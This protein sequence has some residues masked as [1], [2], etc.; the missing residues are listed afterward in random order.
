MGYD[1]KCLYKAANRERKPMKKTGEAWR[2]RKR[3]DKVWED[4]RLEKMPAVAY[5]MWESFIHSLLA[6]ERKRWITET[7]ERLPSRLDP[8]SK[9]DIFEKIDEILLEEDTGHFLR[10]FMNKQQWSQF[11]HD[12]MKIR[13]SWGGNL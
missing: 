9:E 4:T 5:Q 3:F 10:E 11:N 12:I 13:E 7:R 2:F 1:S 6:A 8:V